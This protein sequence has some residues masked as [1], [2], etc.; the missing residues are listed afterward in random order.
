LKLA[1]NAGNER[2]LSD[3]FNVNRRLTEDGY[4]I[5]KGLEGVVL[6]SGFRGTGKTTQWTELRRIM[7]TTTDTAFKSQAINALGCTSDAV[8]LKD[9]L[10]STVVE[11]NNYTQTERQNIFSAVLNSPSG[12]PVVIDFITNFEF[13]ILSLFGYAS[14]EDVLNVPARL[15]KTVDER[16]SFYN[17]IVTLTQ[18]EA[19]NSTRIVL[20]VESNFQVQQQV[21]NV[22]SMEFIRQYL[23]DNQGTTTVPPTETETPTPTQPETPTPTQPGETPTPTQ[24]ETPTPTQSDTEPPPSGAASKSLQ[25][26]TICAGLFIVFILKM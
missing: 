15:I 6:C 16:S 22:Q 5:P 12:L 2:C 21:Q 13:D 18:L 9:Y 23:I 14:L 11:G 1:C 3:T 10:E 4:T 19:S 17:F 8:L 26:I 7:Q 25:F 20:T 24:P